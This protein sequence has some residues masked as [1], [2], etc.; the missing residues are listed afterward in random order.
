MASNGISFVGFRSSSLSSNNNASLGNTRPSVQDSPVSKRS[1]L[2]A[3]AP[4]RGEIL[5]NSIT[6]NSVPSLSVSGPIA[7]FRVNDAIRLLNQ[8]NKATE[9]PTV[10]ALKKSARFGGLQLNRL[11][12]IRIA[13]EDLAD[14]TVELLDDESLNTRRGKTS[15][16]DLVELTVGRGADITISRLAPKQRAVKNRLVSDKQ[17]TALGLTGS[18]L[19]NGFQIDVVAS[20]S[21]FEIRDKINFGEDSNKNGILDGPEDLNENDE[22]DIISVP[23]TE[24]GP[25]RFVIEDV[26]GNG[27]LDADED[28]NGN[29]RLDGGSID[30]NVTAVVL[31]DRLTLTENGGTDKEIILDDADGILLALGFFELNGKGSPILKERQFDDDD[32]AP[33]PIGNLIKEPVP[34]EIQLEGET[35]QSNSNVFDSVI[36]DVEFK[37]KQS[38]DNTVVLKALLDVD[39]AFR[40]IESFTN[41]FN[42][43]IA[44]INETLVFSRAFAGDADI[45]S[46]RR[47][48]TQDIQQ[49]TKELDRRN[50]NISA[51][52]LT[53]ENKKKIGLS[54]KNTEKDIQHEIA[55]TS[56]LENIKRGLSLSVRSADDLFQ[57]L[58]SVGVKTL[59]DDNFDIDSTELKRALAI[60]AD[61]TLD[62]FLNEEIGI[63]P[64]LKSRLDQILNV[65]LGDLDFK[66]T[67]IGISTNTPNILARDFQKFSENQVFENTVQ[68]LITVA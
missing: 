62:L 5:F 38:S 29:G 58:T 20:D 68:N 4:D 46:I 2:N 37:L 48:L 19:V 28:A 41:A 43:A 17:T 6:E 15:R 44:K 7:A 12:G 27:S 40:Q 10:V 56:T 61:E 23:N 26:N 31:N 8:N 9:S 25:G 47:D 24:S 51:L 33:T 14:K 45:Q 16:R 50:K 53:V 57:R 30:H 49:G 22:I 64:Q 42:E 65:N 18:F 59:E 21:I 60:N 11:E 66:E 32:L 36:K 55:I 67:E 52:N 63:L 3:P 34:A 35:V 13:L 39:Q 1:D 54:V